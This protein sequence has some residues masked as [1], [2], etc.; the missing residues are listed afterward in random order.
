MTYQLH[1]DW[2]SLGIGTV[3]TQMDDDGKEFM[4][5][6]VSRSNNN[7]EAQYSSYEGECLAAIWAIVHFRC[8]LYGNEF[9]LVTDHQPL[10]WL[11]ESDKLIGKLAWWALMLME[12]DFKV[13]HRA[14]LVNMD[15]DGLSHNPIPSQ[16][17]AT[18]ARWHVED[19]EDSLP[20]WHCSIFLCLL[21]MHGDTTGE[22]T[23]ATVDADGGEESEGA[24]DIF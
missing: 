3:L 7:A 19:G 23:V 18:G 4:I 10:K 5:A 21:A 13:V 22:A 11:M 15:A 20:G 14:G 8:Y 12:Y 16:A 1:T 6:Y 24:K 9:L 2:S 17:D